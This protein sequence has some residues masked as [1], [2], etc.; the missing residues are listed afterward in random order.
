MVTGVLLRMGRQAT[1]VS[2]LLALSLSTSYS[3]G[4]QQGYQYDILCTTKTTVIQGRVVNQ[5]D[6]YLVRSYK[7]EK[8]FWHIDDGFIWYPVKSINA[9]GANQDVF[10]IEVEQDNSY[11]ANGFV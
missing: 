10:N 6:T 5:Q 11:T 7:T 4:T 9:T 1:T 2:K 3:K 8:H